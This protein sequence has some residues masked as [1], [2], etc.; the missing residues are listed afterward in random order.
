VA[1]SQLRING[2]DDLRKALLALPPQLVNEAGAITHAQAEEAARQITAAYQSHAR[3]G[4]LAGHVRVDIGSDRVSAS[5]R[6]RSTA[7]HAYIFEKGTGSRKWANGKST[8]KMPAGNV[9]IPIAIA[10]RR[11]MTAA[12]VDLVERSG[13]TVTGTA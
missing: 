12:L 2:L 3:T 7:K 10:R 11:I 1:E 6:V 5:A 13:L 9:F 4:N 8:G